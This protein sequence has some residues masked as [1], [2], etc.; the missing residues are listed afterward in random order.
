MEIILGVLSI[1]IGLL[2]WRV[3]HL[4]HKLN[5]REVKFKDFDR[6]FAAHQK[7]EKFI[8]KIVGGRISINDTI[9]FDEEIK[10][11]QYLFNNKIN[12]FAQMIRLVGIDLATLN[13][14]I[15]LLSHPELSQEEFDERKE[16][17]SQ[18]SEIIKKAF[19]EL[20]SELEYI[21]KPLLTINK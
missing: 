15:S 9:L 20:S 8:Y 13:E 1:V 17:M 10:D 21:F 5:E 4:Q 11:F 12:E 19:I 3:S 7:L 16:Y 18:K 2:A 14:K 6:N